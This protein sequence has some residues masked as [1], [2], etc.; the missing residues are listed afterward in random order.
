MNN[1]KSLDKEIKQFVNDYGKAICHKA[2][3][4]GMINS[5]YCGTA[6]MPCDASAEEIAND[7]GLSSKEF[8]Y[9]EDLYYK[10]SSWF[11]N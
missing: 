5:F 2:G 11:N 1:L 6:I 9:W 7:L 4:A 8:D 3:L 10:K